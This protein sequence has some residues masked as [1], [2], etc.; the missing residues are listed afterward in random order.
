MQARCKNQTENGWRRGYVGL[1]QI[2]AE[3]PATVAPG[4]TVPLII[5]AG[6]VTSNTVTIAVE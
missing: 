1:W 5:S 6:G 2:T 4:T 3:V